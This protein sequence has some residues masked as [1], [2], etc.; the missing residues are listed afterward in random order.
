MTAIEGRSIFN[1]EIY[2]TTL[3]MQ[4]LTGTLKNFSRGKNILVT[5]ASGL[6]GLELVKQLLNEGFSVTALYRSNPL[7]ISHSLLTTRQCNILDTSSLEDVMKEAT[8]VYHCA[9]LVSYDKRDQHLLYKINVEGTGNIVNACLNA[10][11]QKLVHVS[12]VAALAAVPGTEFIT[13]EMVW[14]KE[15][16]GGFYSKSKY[17][18]ELEVWRGIGEGLNAVVVNPSIILGVDDWNKGSTALFKSAYNEF[19]YYTEGI[20]GFIDVRDVVRALILLMNSQISAQRFILNAENISYKQ[21]F[22]LMAT[23]F[24]KKPPHKKV[25]SLMADIVWRIEA[26]K[27]GFTHKKQLLTKETA[28]A[29]Q[30]VKKYDNKKFLQAFPD[31]QFISVAQSIDHTCAALKEKYSL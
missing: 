20:T 31:F 3:L 23:C 18:G 7:N 16:S 1:D 25:T 6:V 2:F 17:Y 19:K 28:R 26:L 4:E 30:A 27:A 22:S 13:E 21:L 14:S 29:A 11:V 12:S 8:H 5:G 10:G 24:N 9:A 15:N